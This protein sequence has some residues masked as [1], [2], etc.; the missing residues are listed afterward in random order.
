M[1]LN[2]QQIEQLYTFTHQHY[3]EWYDLQSELVDHLANAIETEWQQ[4]PKC[5]FDEILNSEFKK[6]GIFGFMDVVEECQKFLHKRYAKLIWKFYKE[7]FRLPKIILTFALIYGLFMASKLI[8]KPKYFFLGIL[9]IGIIIVFTDLVKTTRKLKRRE[10]ETG[11]KWLFEDIAKSFNFFPLIFLPMHVFNSLNSFSNTDPWT[12]T[13]AIISA[14]IFVLIG[15]WLFVQLRIIPKKVSEEL[16]KIYS[17][18]Q[19][20][21]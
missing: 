2:E 9:V 20:S 18:Y 3:V 14:S 21:K 7:F 5:T 13:A 8:P 19:I 11:K 15:L 4:N 6:F 1:K 12:N 10:K 16:E 17:D